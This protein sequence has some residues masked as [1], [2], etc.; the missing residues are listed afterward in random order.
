MIVYFDMYKE[1]NGTL[2]IVR[3]MEHRRA[4][5]LES[6]YYN[7]NLKLLCLEWL[8]KHLR[9]APHKICPQQMTQGVNSLVIE[10]KSF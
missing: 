2:R 4:S 9:F 7:L 8:E 10:I 5:F 6:Q 1:E 3:E